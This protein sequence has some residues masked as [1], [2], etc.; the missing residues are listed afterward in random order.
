MS[1]LSAVSDV[2]DPIKVDGNF[3]VLGLNVGLVKRVV[4]A[5]KVN[6]NGRVSLGGKTVM[7]VQFKHGL[8]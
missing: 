3:L 2:N 7:S 1:A 8:Y 6:V 4:L 5:G